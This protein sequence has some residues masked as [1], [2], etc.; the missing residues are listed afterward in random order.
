MHS[1]MRRCQFANDPKFQPCLGR[2]STLLVSVRTV[3][4][5]SGAVYCKHALVQAPEASRAE[6]WGG[7]KD[8]D[9]DEAVIKPKPN[10]ISGITMKIHLQLPDLP[11]VVGGTKMLKAGRS[12]RLGR[13]ID[14]SSA[15]CL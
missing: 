15:A 7:L 8:F 1:P 11:V 14:C 4:S 13:N 3:G 2:I 9:E 6:L 12:Q 5:C 10:N